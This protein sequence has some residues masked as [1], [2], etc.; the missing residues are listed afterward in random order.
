MSKDTR[1][2]NLP[3]TRNQRPPRTMAAATTSGFTCRTWTTSRAVTTAQLKVKYERSRSAKT[4]VWNEDLPAWEE[5]GKLPDLRAQLGD[6]RLPSR[7]GR[8]RRPR[9]LAAA[10][11]ESF[12]AKSVAKRSA[13]PS[14]VE[15]AA[16]AS[17]V[18][19]SNKQFAEG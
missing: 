17:R 19:E 4:Y 2:H 7:R 5:I 6:P 1:A 15:L 16:R 10:R 11:V 18:C 3:P 13:P 8:S 12:A 14:R 9:P